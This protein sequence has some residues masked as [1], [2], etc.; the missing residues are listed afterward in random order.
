MKKDGFTLV[1]LLS[2]IV[3]IG[4]VSIIAIPSVINSIQKAKQKAYDTQMSEIIAA[5]KKWSSNNTD[6]LDE[7]HLNN[8]Y[9]T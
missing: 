6:K 9:I 1:E 4:V 7:Y 8:T 5:A 2:T 3:I